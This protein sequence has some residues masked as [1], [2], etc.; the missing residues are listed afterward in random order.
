MDEAIVNIT[1]PTCNRLEFTKRTLSAVKKHTRTPHVLTVVDNGST[2]GTPEFLVQLARDGLIDNLILFRRN[3][4]VACAANMGFDVGMKPLYLKLD[5]DMEVVRPDWLAP[6]VGLWCD[7]PEVSLIGPRLPGSGHPFETVTL[8][9]GARVLRALSNLSGAALLV[10]ADVCGKLGYFCEDYGLYGEEDA[11]Y[12]HRAKEAGY[13]LT[14][15]DAA[16]VVRHLGEVSRAQPGYA[17]LKTRQREKNTRNARGISPF[18][19]NCYLYNHRLVPLR[20][21]RRYRPVKAEGYYWDVALEAA[22]SRRRKFV[23][24]CRK[25]IE[26]VPLALW[27][28]VLGSEEFVSGLR[29]LPSRQGW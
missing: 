9:G 27:D 3:M 21:P 24:E 22:Y 5:N 25:R 10:S 2:D 6:L 23:Q 12:S 14:A 4:G 15:F 29:L 1:V 18:A 19:L 28:E 8:P 11:D 13:L 7:T 20:V 16:G 17:A 26:A